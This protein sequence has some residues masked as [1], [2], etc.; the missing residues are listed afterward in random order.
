MLNAR[1]L[2]QTTGQSMECI[3]ESIHMGLS[4]RR[5]LLPPNQHM[6]ILGY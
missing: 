4:F 3:L 1:I 2:P 5:F 6:G